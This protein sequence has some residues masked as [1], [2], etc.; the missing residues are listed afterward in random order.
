MCV[1]MYFCIHYELCIMYVCMYVYFVYMYV[2]MHV[3]IFLF[4][5]DIS[6]LHYL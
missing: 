5:Y 2:R 1:C 4:I 3:Y 6:M